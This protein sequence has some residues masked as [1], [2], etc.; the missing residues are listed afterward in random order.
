MLKDKN[1]IYSLSK[2]MGVLAR[3]VQQKL[4][5]KKDFRTTKYGSNKNKSTLMGTFVNPLLRDQGSNLGHPP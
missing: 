3:R 4:D 2:P 1:L 5:A